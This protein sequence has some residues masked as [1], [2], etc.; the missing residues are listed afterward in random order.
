MWEV[1]VLDYKFWLPLIVNLVWVGLAAFQIRIQ[2]RQGRSPTTAGDSGVAA[3]KSAWKHYWPIVV[4]LFLMLGA[5]LPYVVR[6]KPTILITRPVL[7]TYGQMPAPLRVFGV[8]DE[9]SLGKLADSDRIMLMTR[10][11]D[12]TVD[13]NYDIHT[14]HSHL[15]D[16]VP[17]LNQIE[18]PVSQSFIAKENSILM[19]IIE[20]YVVL[21]PKNVDESQVVTIHDAVKLGGQLLQGAGFG[22]TNALAPQPDP[23]PQTRTQ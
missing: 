16:I 19:G 11:T 10:I 7:Q 5:W 18:I 6:E 15:R 17:G 22:F 13:P 9:T 4:M 3:V 21:L 1:R 12:N 2:L 20:V 8:V 14:E 23:V